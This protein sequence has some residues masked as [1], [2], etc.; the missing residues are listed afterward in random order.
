MEQP[1]HGFAELFKQLGLPAGDAEIAQFLR[2]HAP[3]QASVAL[4]EAPFWTEAQAGLLR[5]ALAGDADWA[6]IVDQLDAALRRP[7]ARV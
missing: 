6:E 4:A 1:F 7:Q 5:D 3:L 2:Q